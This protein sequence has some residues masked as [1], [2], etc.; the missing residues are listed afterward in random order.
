MSVDDVMFERALSLGAVDLK[1]SWRK[2]KKYAVLF[3]GKWIHFGDSRYDD[4]RIHKD[5]DRRERYLKR[6]Y[7]VRNKEGRL[8][9]YDKDSANYWSINLLW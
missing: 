3:D 6:A 5:L 7:A 9:A 8:T 1:P 2:H 4:F